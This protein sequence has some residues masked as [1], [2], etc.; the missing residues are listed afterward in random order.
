MFVVSS[1]LICV[2][3]VVFNG[4][5]LFFGVVLLVDVVFVVFGCVWVFLLSLL[6]SILVSWLSVVWEIMVMEK[7]VSGVWNMLD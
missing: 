3:S 4:C 2:W 5:G 6:C 1:W 7:F